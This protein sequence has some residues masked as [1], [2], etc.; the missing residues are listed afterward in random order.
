MVVE[1]KLKVIR[2][3]D[4]P[5]QERKLLAKWLKSFCKDCETLLKRKGLKTCFEKNLTPHEPLILS[6]SFST[7]I[8]SPYS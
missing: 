8:C 2:I 1:G 3:S 4:V 6:R 5:E 7:I